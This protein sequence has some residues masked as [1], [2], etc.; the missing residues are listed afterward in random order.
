[1]NKESSSPHPWHPIV[2]VV[3]VAAASAAPAAAA[4][5]SNSLS[6]HA[7]YGDEVLLSLSPLYIRDSLQDRPTHQTSLLPVFPTIPQARLDDSRHPWRTPLAT[8]HPE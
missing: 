5:A 1:M 6:C 4:F 3:P 2:S 8:G 7:L